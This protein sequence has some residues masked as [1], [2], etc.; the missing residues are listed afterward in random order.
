MAKSRAIEEARFKAGSFHFLLVEV[1]AV[2]GIVGFHFGSWWWFGGAF[3]AL[4]AL[5]SVP[6]IRFFGAI[7]LAIAGALAIALG[8]GHYLSST[9]SLGVGVVALAVLC[10]VNAAAAKHQDD[11]DAVDARTKAR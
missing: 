2:S 4:C 3:V 5:V 6:G 1:L 8:A 11:L 9:A 10:T 7:G